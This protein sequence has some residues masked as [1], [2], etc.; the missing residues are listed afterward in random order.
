MQIVTPSSN[1]GYGFNPPASGN[2]GGG[3]SFNNPAFLTSTGGLSGTA[4]I[5]MA[6]AINTVTGKSVIVYF[7][8]ND[9]NCEEN[10]EYD[11]RQ[12]ADFGQ[13]PAEGRSGAFH[14]I[15]LKYRELGYARFNINITVFDKTLDDFNTVSIPVS[16][17]VLP[18][19]TKKR[20][21][22]FP[23]KR[24]HTVRLT[25]PKGVFQ[26]ERPQITITRNA[27]SGPESVTRITLCGNADEMAQQ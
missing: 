19:K 16:I 6:P 1:R 21:Q 22:S 15:I 2:K 14:L 18:L 25:P 9:F 8:S 26:G 12:E 13:F 7:N 5:L 10:A 3:A 4:G 27:N 24:I 20:Q 17:P 11:F 23:D